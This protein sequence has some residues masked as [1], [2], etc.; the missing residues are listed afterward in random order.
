MKT[1]LSISLLLISQILTAQIIASKSDVEEFNFFYSDSANGE[2]AYGDYEPKD[3]I[4]LNDGSFLIGTELSISFP[5]HYKTTSNY[6]STYFAKSK[7]FREKSHSSSGTVFKLSSNFEKEWE[8]FF[9]GQRIKRIFKTTDNKILIAGEDVS[10]KFVW[11]AELDINGNILWEKHFKYKNSVT[12]ADAKIDENNDI[13]LTLESSH[14]IPF[15]VQKYYG[16]RRIHLFKDSEI[17]SHLALLKVSSKGKRKWLKPIDKTRKYN[18]FGFNLVVGQESY[19]ASFIYS[20]FERD[21][22]IEGKR[23]IEISKTGKTILTREIPK[24]EILLFCNGLVTITSHSN[25]KLFLYKS[26]EIIDSI[27]IES[28]Y[29]DVRIEKSI[30][31]PNGYLIF[32]SNYDKNMDYLLVNLSSN[33][34]FLNYWTF[35]REEYNEIRGA[36]TLDNGDIIIV[37]KCYREMKGTSNE[38]TTYINL[39]K[40]KNGA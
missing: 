12:I 25:G 10:M 33:L 32:G 28:A 18:K 24:Q 22:L 11:L 9:N 27:Y 16:K 6:D 17:N 35:P 36:I 14:I 34:K 8:T 13:L 40:I 39:I 7:I 20:G 30:H 19:F 21:S 15:Q 31:M 37:G 4:R 23:V 38:L 1:I 29:K 5:S 3:I 26:G 2:F